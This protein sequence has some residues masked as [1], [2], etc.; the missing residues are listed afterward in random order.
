[1]SHLSLVSNDEQKNTYAE[2]LNEKAWFDYLWGHS[3]DAPD[4]AQDDRNHGRCGDPDADSYDDVGFVCDI[5]DV[6]IYEE[7]GCYRFGSTF[8]LVVNP[9]CGKAEVSEGLGEKA[10]QAELRDITCDIS[11]DDNPIIGDLTAV[12]A[13]YGADCPSWLVNDR[14]EDVLIY[15]RGVASCLSRPLCYLEVLEAIELARKGVI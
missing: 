4:W 10:L 12:L 9:A 15:L 6:G 7:P 14:H 8:T 11:C 13:I 2:N 5:L 3:T 1:M